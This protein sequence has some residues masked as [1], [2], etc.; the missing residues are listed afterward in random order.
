MHTK[1]LISLALIGALAACDVDEV[2]TDSGPGIDAGEPGDAARPEYPSG[3]YGT[4]IGSTTQNVT[5]M[6]YRAHHDRN[7]DP[8]WEQIQLDDYYDPLENRGFYGG[9]LKLMVVDIGAV[10]CPPC[11]LETAWLESPCK[12]YETKGLVCYSAVLEG[13]NRGQPATQTDADTWREL[14]SDGA[15]AVPIV[16]ADPEGNWLPYTQNSFPTNIFVDLKTMKI[17]DQVIG[18]DLTQ[19]QTKMQK[20]L[21]QFFEEEGS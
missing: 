13:E 3:P 16:V 18:S 15:P 7:T 19:L 8:S 12:A 9:S 4:T 5:L 21:K 2:P 10:W 20:Y 1:T 17:I 6:G 14:Q 11:R